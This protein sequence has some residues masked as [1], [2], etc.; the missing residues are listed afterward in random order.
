MKKIRCFIPN[1]LL[2]FLLVFL[3]IG[4]EATVLAD[5]IALNPMTF[6][7]LTDQQHLDAK[8]YAALETYFKT[9]S[10][11]TGIPESVFL[12]DDSYTEADLRS[13]IIQNTN[14]ALAYINGQ[15]AAY[16]FSPDFA[17]LEGAVRT[18]FED[19]ADK[20]GYK[21]DDVLEEKIHSTCAEAEAAIRNSADPFKFGT[22]YSNG[23][24]SKARSAVT[25][26]LKL[27]E[28]GCIA[29]IIVILILLI[30]C[31]IKQL[32][33]LCYWIGL[34]GFIAGGLMAAPCIYLTAT[35]YYSSFAIK[36]PQIFSAVIGYLKLLTSR[37]LTMAII[38]AI[39]GFIGLMGFILL[40]S[41]QRE[42]TA[43]KS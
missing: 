15:D 2:T 20:N 4:C 11:S 14:V 5:R 16:D 35:D 27:A 32:E 24:L 34:A 37:C 22:L 1:I 7:V 13:A 40:R 31:N 25:G 3:L 17:K 42:D 33:H 10:N 23:V 30:I 43:A 38:T 6:Q 28:C 41:A 21:K 18:F 36:D 9:R 19:Y 8:G 39:V 12:S 26:Y 29:G